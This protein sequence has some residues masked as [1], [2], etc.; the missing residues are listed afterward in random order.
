MRA[1]VDTQSSLVES[2]GTTAATAATVNHGHRQPVAG[3]SSCCSLALLR[4][5]VCVCVLRGSAL[6]KHPATTSLRR[7]TRCMTKTNVA[8]LAWSSACAVVRLTKARRATSRSKRGAEI[9]LAQ[10][11]VRD[12]NSSNKLTSSSLFALPSGRTGP[13]S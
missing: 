1:H 13:A 3:V 12:S 7:E 6:R 11:S 5:C 10:R 4:V 8:Q 9:S 2:T